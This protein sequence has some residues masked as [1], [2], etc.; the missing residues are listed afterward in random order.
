MSSWTC[1]WI[2]SINNWGSEL[3]IAIF[4]NIK[5]WKDFTTSLTFYHKHW[6]FN[7]STSI[8]L[9]SYNISKVAIILR[10]T[11]DL[12]R[13]WKLKAIFSIDL[14]I[15]DT[16]LM[17]YARLSR[18]PLLFRSFTGLAITEFDIIS[19][20]IESKYYEHERKRLSNRKSKRDVVRWEQ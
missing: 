6:Q 7:Y 5:S 16:V 9:S 4:S 14:D 12:L 15:F 3:L 13:N 18:R 17:S 1:T 2:V 8:R 19:K 10:Y 20:E 11:L